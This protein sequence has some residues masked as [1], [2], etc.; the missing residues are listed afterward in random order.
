[1]VSRSS[2]EGP[3]GHDEQSGTTVSFPYDRMTVEHFRKSFP[4]ARWS[5][6][7]KAWFVPGKTAARR[8]D[9]WREREFAGSDAYA[10]MRG[11]DA[12]A[13]DPIVS[14]YLTLRE[15][16]LEVQT[17]FSRTI[18]EELRQVPFA[19]WDGDRRVWTIP[20]RSYEDLRRR[21]AA[22]E[23]AARRNEPEARRQRQAEN[24]G[25]ARERAARIR[26]TERRRRR[27]PLPADQLPPL[28]VPVMT[29]AFGILVFIGSDGELVD[30]ETLAAHYPDLPAGRAYVWG[31]WRPA[32]H[33]ELIKTWPAR[34][35]SGAKGGGIWW[36]PTLD[37][38]RAA[39]KAA[40]ALE[41]R[42]DRAAAAKSRPSG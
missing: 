12:C 7:L 16:H 25:S 38:L 8:F 10:D 31:R 28:E 22:I 32:E 11:K 18:V 33:S 17:P 35:G 23:D 30:P 19:S 15:H 5:D 3:R 41:R 40:R 39:R 26:A 1:M 14:Q 21:W 37:E 36:Q 13:F 27:H 29:A 9:R 4:R 2:D 6:D 42:L 34:P 24:R 20:Y